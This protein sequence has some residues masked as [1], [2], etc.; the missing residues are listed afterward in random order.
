MALQVLVV[1]DDPYARASVRALLSAEPGVEVAGEAGNGREALEAIERA[2]P[3]ILILDVD[4]PELDGFGVLEALGDERAPVVVFVTAHEEH[5]LRAFEVHALDYLVKPFGME[6]FRQAFARARDAVE[7]R[8]EL[9]RGERIHSLLEQVRD[10]QRGLRRLVSGE[11]YLQRLMVKTSE[12]VILLATDEIDWVEAE[13][14]YVR[15]HV[16]K[17]AHLVRWKIGAL[18]ERLD[19]RRFVRIHRSTVVNLE[20]VKELR[21][22]FAG[23]FIVAMK[24]GTELKLSRSYR[25]ELEKR[26]GS[27]A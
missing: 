14:N 1:D 2:E 4:M 15:L 25:A 21:P 9:R 26:L 11:P 22:W 18:E 17:S 16:G 24:D 10:E 19:P 8:H 3:D 12:R 20:R 5:A 23:D 6:R 27:A 13:G 7:E